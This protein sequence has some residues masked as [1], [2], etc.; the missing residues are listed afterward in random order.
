M[1]FKDAH[2]LK[3][4]IPCSHFYFGFP[5]FHFQVMEIY[6]VHLISRHAPIHRH[7]E[8]GKGPAK[9]A[10]TDDDSV[11]IPLFFIMPSATKIIAHSEIEALQFETLAI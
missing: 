8:G 3:Q 9:M 11:K 1:I 5:T 4:P 2:R 10:S 6:V 7:V